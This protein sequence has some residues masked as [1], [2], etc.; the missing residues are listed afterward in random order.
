MTPDAVVSAAE[1]FLAP[2]RFSGV[3]A[4][5]PE[6]LAHPLALNDVE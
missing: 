2:G 5:D 6:V 1:E 3:V 4:V